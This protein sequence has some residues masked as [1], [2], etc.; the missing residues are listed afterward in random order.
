MAN[1]MINM[2]MIKSTFLAALIAI[3]SVTAIVPF[4]GPFGMDGEYPR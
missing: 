4:G 3:S 2:I 1:R